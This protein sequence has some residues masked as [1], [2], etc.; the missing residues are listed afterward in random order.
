ME[1]MQHRIIVIPTTKLSI[2]IYKRGDLASPSKLPVHLGRLLTFTI[3]GPTLAA[4]SLWVHQIARL[5]VLLG[6]HG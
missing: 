5:A 2:C 1:Y 3:L 6:N 4:V